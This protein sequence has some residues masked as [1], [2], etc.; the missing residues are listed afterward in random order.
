MPDTEIKSDPAPTPIMSFLQ[1]RQSMQNIGVKVFKRVLQSYNFASGVIGWKI[2]ADGTIEAV[3]VILSG[4]IT[5]LGFVFGVAPNPSVVD[6][7]LWCALNGSYK[8][9]WGYW[10]GI[11]SKQQVSMSKMFAY[12]DWDNDNTG[13]GSVLTKDLEIDTW[14]QPRSVS[15]NG[16]LINAAN[17]ELGVCY[18]FAQNGQDGIN[19]GMKVK[20]KSVTN[21]VSGLSVSNGSF[22]TVSNGATDASPLIPATLADSGPWRINSYYNNTGKQLLVGDSF[23]VGNGI[24]SMSWTNNSLTVVDSAANW[25]QGNCLLSSNYAT[26]RTTLD[27]YAYVLSWTDTKIIIR[28]VCQPGFRLF[29][30]FNVIG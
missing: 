3:N 20:V 25:Q 23:S 28:I 27:A 7:T 24:A 22:V 9:L 10:G 29:C 14:F 18:G 19:T 6:G 21:V 16:F 5:A 8:V 2:S 4:L 17:T 30:H 26:D 12:G 13:G 1:L 15:A 11:T